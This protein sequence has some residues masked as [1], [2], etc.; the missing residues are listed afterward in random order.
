MQGWKKQIENL[1]IKEAKRKAWKIKKRKNFL[2]KK[3]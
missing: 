1:I 3:A 2:K